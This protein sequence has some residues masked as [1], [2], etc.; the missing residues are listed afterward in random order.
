VS[1]AIVEREQHEDN[2]VSR[3][4]NVQEYKIKKSI[5]RS[6]RFNVRSS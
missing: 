1:I 6:L 2:I 3:V 4:A 5:F